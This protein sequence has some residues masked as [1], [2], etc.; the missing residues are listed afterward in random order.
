MKNSILKLI[1]EPSPLIYE[2]VYNH[3]GQ[4]VL[5]KF[6]TAIKIN[7]LDLLSKIY[8]YKGLDINDYDVPDIITVE[9]V[10]DNPDHLVNLDA[11]IKS[12]NVSLI[13]VPE[14]SV[15]NSS[16]QRAL[17]FR[18]KISE[19]IYIVDNVAHGVSVNE[20]EQNDHNSLKIDSSN[21]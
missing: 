3:S 14:V 17:L 13:G 1:N 12:E 16:G 6:Y 10:S 5:D 20:Y 15:M 2:E 21:L 4:F 18:F 8:E 11:K 7:N 19:L 9:I